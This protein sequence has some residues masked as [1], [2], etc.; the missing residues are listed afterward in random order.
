MSKRRRGVGGGNFAN[1]AI[2]A[3]FGYL[4]NFC[5]KKT[6]KCTRWTFPRV[7][8][9]IVREEY[10][11]ADLV[12]LVRIEEEDALMHNGETCGVRYT[13]S[14]LIQA[15]RCS[16]RRIWPQRGAEAR[17]LYLLFLRYIT[18]PSDYY[19]TLRVRENLLEEPAAEKQK[20]VEFLKCGGIIPGLVYEVRS[21][22]EV[23]LSYAIVE[24][25]R[26]GLPK[27]V[28]VWTSPDLMSSF[29]KDDFFAYLAP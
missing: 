17:R 21:A 1:G 10:R 13:G 29:N 16:E 22:W 20:S 25:I 15:R 12:L 9:V 24:G 19:E 3:A 18:D 8:N 4:F 28:R 14:G 26:P 2:A 23:K 27:S 5:S 7:E 11:R 6:E